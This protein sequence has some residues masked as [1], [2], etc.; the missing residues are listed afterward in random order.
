M[1]IELAMD[2]RLS[3]E[4]LGKMPESPD[5]WA[6][7]NDWEHRDKL[8]AIGLSVLSAYVST[9]DGT[10][11]RF[12]LALQ[13][14]PQDGTFFEEAT[15]ASVEAS[16]LTLSCWVDPRTGASGLA[17]GMWA[18]RDEEKPMSA[19]IVPAPDGMRAN[20]VLI[21]IYG[22]VLSD[23]RETMLAFLSGDLRPDRLWVI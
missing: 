16:A 7:M 4:Q 13:L 6:I 12:L 14:N 21:R 15:L 8:V 19:V 2:V 18:N 20:R 3:T 23:L 17:C 11:L 22:S 9:F 5:T 10:S 1:D